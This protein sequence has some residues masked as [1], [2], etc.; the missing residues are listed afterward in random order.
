M[1][2]LANTEQIEL[3]ISAHKLLREISLSMFVSTISDEFLDNFKK[4]NTIEQHNKMAKI[5]N[6]LVKQFHKMDILAKCKKIP[7]DTREIIKKYYNIKVNTLLGKLNS[8]SELNNILLID[9]D[10]KYVSNTK[11]VNCPKLPKVDIID[12]TRRIGQDSPKMVL[13][14][15]GGRCNF[16][17]TEHL[18]SCLRVLVETRTNWTDITIVPHDYKSK[19]EHGVVELRVN[20]ILH[21]FA[22]KIN[23]FPSASDNSSNPYIMS[24]D[25]RLIHLLFG[26]IIPSDTSK[27]LK[28]L[29][30][31][32]VYAEFLE[33]VKKRIYTCINNAYN[34]DSCELQC[35]PCCRTEPNVCACINISTKQKFRGKYDSGITCCLECDLELCGGGCGKAYHGNTPCDAS[36]DE[37]TE[38][39][40]KS[41]CVKCPN[42]MVN[43]YKIYGC[44]H[45]KCDMC[46]THFCYLC[47]QQYSKDSHGKDM[48]TEHYNN[49]D[50]YGSCRA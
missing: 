6:D 31:Y 5:I 7:V 26:G 33:L 20:Y 50:P 17:S 42:C 18:M 32:P 3:C 34:V 48:I 14:V 40:I 35:I 19:R 36:E 10:L 45:M 39:L 47:A 8:E 11:K 41:E 24:N 29:K 30:F 1:E 15:V 2:H 43:T 9:K 21:R 12:S 44:N 38:L 27:T 46:F 49:M 25:S 4:I 37:Q 23:F 22:M 13:H 16:D 28:N